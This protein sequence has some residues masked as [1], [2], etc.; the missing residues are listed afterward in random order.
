MCSQTVTTIVGLLRSSHL[1]G[2]AF[3]KILKKEILIGAVVGLLA[4]LLVALSIFVFS[5]WFTGVSYQLATLI[6]AQLWTSVLISIGIPL[7]ISRMGLDPLVSAPSLAVILSSVVS[8][9]L[10]MGFYALG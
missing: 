2:K 7:L 6:V 8:V 9:I 4:G 5:S 10:L 1:K 3:L